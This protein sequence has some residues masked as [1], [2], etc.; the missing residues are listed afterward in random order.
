MDAALT[1]V[2]VHGGGVVVLLDE[3]VDGA[4]VAA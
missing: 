2:A 3:G 4:E 1:E